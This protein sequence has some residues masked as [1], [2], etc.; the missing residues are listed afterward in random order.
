MAQYKM[1]WKFDNIEN[2]ENENLGIS[3][4]DVNDE[5]RYNI[6]D[7]NKDLV[8]EGKPLNYLE[9]D[10]IKEL[11]QLGDTQANN[12]RKEFK[13]MISESLEEIINEDENDLDFLR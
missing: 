12:M 3:T 11:T 6:Y 1:G 4:E 5:L 10:S 13:N 9:I 2:I 8:S 7:K